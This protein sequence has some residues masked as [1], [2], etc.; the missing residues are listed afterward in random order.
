M[1]FLWDLG[2][3]RQPGVEGERSAQRSYDQREGPPSPTM[4]KRQALVNLPLGLSDFHAL[5]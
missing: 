4:L 2:N 5:D 1:T 3:A